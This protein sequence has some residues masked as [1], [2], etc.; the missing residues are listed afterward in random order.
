MR[1]EQVLQLFWVLPRGFSWFFLLPEVP[2]LSSSHY[3]SLGTLVLSLNHSLCSGTPNSL[4]KPEHRFCLHLP[5]LWILTSLL[6]LFYPPAL[7][8]IH[9][10]SSQNLLT[11]RYL[12]NR[13]SPWEEQEEV[14]WLLGKDCSPTVAKTTKNHISKIARRR[15]RITDLVV[16]SHTL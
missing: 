14:C 1:L 12:I 13:K 11:F 10:I 15:G 3:A 5:S 9:I 7:S 8:L 16:N 2:Y 4:C 6:H